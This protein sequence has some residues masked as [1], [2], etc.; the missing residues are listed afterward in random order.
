MSGEEFTRICYDA[1]EELKKRTPIDTGNMRNNAVTIEFFDGG[2]TCKIY[3]DEQIAPYVFYTNEK[4]ISP[5]WNGKEN[6]N[7]KWFDKASEYIVDFL[8]QRLSG[9][10]EKKDDSN[11]ETD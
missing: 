2:K 6:P 1:V 8:T 5:K 9:T 4:W 3:V 11:Q 7:E 10:T